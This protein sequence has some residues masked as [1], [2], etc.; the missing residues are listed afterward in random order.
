MRFFVRFDPHRPYQF[1]ANRGSKLR[2]GFHRQQIKTSL[3]RN[4]AKG[5]ATR[6]RRERMGHPPAAQK[7]FRSQA[8]K[9]TFRHGPDRV[10]L[11]DADDFDPWENLRWETVRVLFYWQQKPA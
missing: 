5:W 1:H 3:F 4:V 7:R 2:R 9:L 10:E 6:Q 11:W 8:P